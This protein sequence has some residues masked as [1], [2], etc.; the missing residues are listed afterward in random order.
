M[1]ERLHFHFS[2][3]CIG[4]GN[5]NRLQCSVNSEHWSLCFCL[6]VLS[7]SLGNVLTYLHRSAEDSQGTPYPSS[8]LHL[9]AALFP[10][11]PHSAHPTCLDLPVG[12]PRVPLPHAAPWTLAPGLKL[13]QS[14]G[15][16]P[17]F[18]LLRIPVLCCLMPKVWKM[19][20]HFF[21]LWFYTCL[22]KSCVLAHS[23]CHNIIPQTGL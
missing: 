18:P 15:L 17:V 1:T 7:S 4:E 14:Q 21:F 23:G 2:L 9:C 10:L 5:G 11:G 20:S 22:R 8:K 19:L 12:S 3:S 6:V 13:G 16:P